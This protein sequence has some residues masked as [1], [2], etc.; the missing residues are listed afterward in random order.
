MKQLLV[1]LMILMHG[2]APAQIEIGKW[3]EHL[4]YKTGVAVCKA[5]DRVYCSA[6]SSLF[7]FDTKDNSLQ[8]ITKSDGL[9]D[10]EINV[11]KFSDKHNTLIVGYN[12]GN[13]DL[14]VNNQIINVPDVKRSFIQG[15]KAIN[16]VLIADNFA[17][18]STGFGII[19][20]NL[21]KKEISETFTLGSGGTQ[22]EVNETCIK[23]D[24]LFAATKEGILVGSL[25][26]NLVDFQN[27]FKIKGLPP[28]NYNTIVNFNEEI[29]TNF[30]MVGGW[31]KDTIYSYYNGS[32]KHQVVGNEYN[33]DNLQD[34]NVSDNNELMIAY[35]FGGLIVNSNYQT[36]SKIWTYGD[37]LEAPVTREIIKDNNVYW[38]ADYKSS[39][40]KRKSE[41]DSD[42][43]AP[44]GP[45]FS[46]SWK[47]DYSSGHLWVATG[48][49]T[50][51]MKYSF[52]NKGI[53]EFSD[54]KWK[55]YYGNSAFDSLRDIHAIAIN[56]S[57][58]KHIFA[59]SYGGG[60]L[61]FKD[62]QRVKIH[63][64]TNSKIQS[65][66]LF[67]F[68][69]I[70]E[71]AFDDK[72]KLW[73][74]NGGLTGY[75]TSKPLVMYDLAEKNWY[76]YSLNNLLSSSSLLLNLMVDKNGNK[77]M[78]GYLKGLIVFNE[79]GTYENTD[80]DQ[81]KL[82][83]V[84]ENGGNLPSNEVNAIAEDQDGK[85]WIGTS[86]G[87][88]VFNAPQNVF[89]AGGINAEKIIIEENGEA[90]Y[91]LSDEVINAIAVDAGNRKWIGT[92]GSGVFL[93]SADM[94]TEI[95]HFTTLNSPLLSD[96]IFDIVIND[97][98][99]EV[100]ISTD[101]GLV[102][103]MGSA[104]DS[105]DY[106]GPIYSYPNPVPPH[107]NGIIGIKGVVNN[108]EVK[109][110]DISGNL[111]YETFANGGTVTWD[112]KKLDGKKVQ[113]GVYLVLV[114][115]SDGSETQITKIAF[116]N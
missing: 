65:I 79:N 70:G 87:L 64:E 95:H 15:N 27:W 33:H 108:A 22:L 19:S 94:Q 37:D 18:L 81:L 9:S 30:R 69:A 92:A 13:I 112:G 85:I 72:N 83:T 111:V 48:T 96:V 84:A 76:A 114:S 14:I 47:M 62:G 78:S 55:S 93:M 10:L 45:T 75:S 88:A 91:L 106:D 25:K 44:E 29:V 34:L 115:N 1:S 4:S 32:W 110:T 63:D 28:G 39:L 67:P 74:A 103:F 90:R 59:A 43:Y 50:N 73:I 2:I 3:R 56:P 104:T 7:Y 58:P 107:Y 68:K 26:D 66:S 31:Q 86:T 77:W 16:E 80:D 54:E 23:N 100:F 40:I 11:I 116:L 41:F 105:N 61:E 52:L 20:L 82:L 51:N 12:N 102:G 97:Q 5:N 113:S 49:L 89:T 8:K 17:Y 98:S 35:D 24:S 99:G 53:A 46:N 71:L 60:V 6:Y 38:I 36:I 57:N 109:I 42:Q 21:V 101:K